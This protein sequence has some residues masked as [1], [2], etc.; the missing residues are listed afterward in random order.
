M[1][2]YET[3]YHMIILTIFLLVLLLCGSA[4]AESVADDPVVVRVGD[5]SYTQS[6][7]QAS[8][9]NAL[10][11]SEMLRGDAPSEEEKAARLET[12]I[13]S[14]I[15]MGIIENKLTEA[16][17]NDFSET[18]LE[19]LNQ[20]ASS[21]YDEF[22]QLLYQQMQKANESVEEK[23]VT[24][25]MEAMGYTF[26]AILNEY[27]L[28]ARQNRAVELFV[29]DFAL[30]QDQVDAYYEEQF[31]APDREDYKDDLEKYEME[32]LANDNDSFYTPEGYR[33]IRQIVLQYPE[34]AISACKRLQIQMS[35]AAQSLTKALQTLTLA[36]TEF[37]GTT[38]AISEAKTA[39]DSAA[40]QMTDAQNQYMDAL[41]QA[42]EPLVKDQI[43][44]IMAQFNAGIDFGTLLNKYS[45]DRTDKNL[46]GDG[47]PFH[48]DSP[49]WPQTF[50]DAARALEKPGDISEP[51][52]TEQGVHI[53][54]YAGDV[55]AG[56]HVLTDDERKLLNAAALRYYQLEK[57]DGLLEGWRADY[58]I[59]THPEL[60]TY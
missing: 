4:L 20:A 48:P 2:L 19:D 26:E 29:G 21:K 3:L 31:V 12:A 36:A 56:E 43:D 18:E 23:D 32:I 13:E 50:I 11:I 15:D 10:E 60:L 39:Y 59:E 58:E 28:Q 6:Q 47:Y 9:D 53:L 45:T 57:L 42:T 37:D 41:R 51:V 27:I 22:W 1:C 49:N 44:E 40:Q 38:E 17:K 33:Y 35:R 34:E 55:P 7:L 25:T 16:G 46:N 14:Y 24:E 5:F 54:Y 30:S 52:Y 8:L